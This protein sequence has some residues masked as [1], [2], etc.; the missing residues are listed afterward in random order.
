[1]FPPGNNG[2]LVLGKGFNHTADKQTVS[3]IL[4][5]DLSWLFWGEYFQS[6]Q[7]QPQ[8]HF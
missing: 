3:E 4:L 5:S 8:I 1:M 7:I 6:V 2:K